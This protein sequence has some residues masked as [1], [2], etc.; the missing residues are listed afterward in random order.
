[1]NLNSIHWALFVIDIKER[2][3]DYFDS[4]Y[5]KKQSETVMNRLNIM[6]QYVQIH[7]IANMGIKWMHWKKMHGRKHI[8]KKAFLN[9]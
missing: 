5:N 4:L 1:M 7:T 9:K 6:F 2:H 8:P 3:I